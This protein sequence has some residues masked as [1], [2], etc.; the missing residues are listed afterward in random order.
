M[1]SQIHRRAADGIHWNSEAVPMRVNVFLTHFCLSRGIELKNRWKESFPF[2]PVKMTENILLEEAKLAQRAAVLH[3]RD[4]LVHRG[5]KPRKTQHQRPFVH[6]HRR[7]AKNGGA[8]RG[9]Q[10][11]GVGYN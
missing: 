7:K 2:N 10:N 1:A 5:N 3:F 4:R 9:P 11:A 6:A 8:R